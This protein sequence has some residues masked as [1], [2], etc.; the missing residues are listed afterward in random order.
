MRGF[1]ARVP[2]DFLRLHA[3]LRVMV[4][5]KIILVAA[6]SKFSYDAMVFQIVS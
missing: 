3:G 2:A 1:R 6:R 5:P 4:P